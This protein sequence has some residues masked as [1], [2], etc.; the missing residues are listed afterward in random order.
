MGARIKKTLKVDVSEVVRKIKGKK[1]KNLYSGVVAD[2]EKIGTKKQIQKQIIEYEYDRNKSINFDFLNYINRIF[3]LGL[4]FIMP[5]YLSLLS[6]LI[7]A[8]FLEYKDKGLDI[9]KAFNYT[10]S[11]INSISKELFYIIFA[12]TFSVVIIKAIILLW[13][14]NRIISEKKAFLILKEIVNTLD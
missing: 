6:N 5:I 13:I 10:I 12:A 7:W 14:N 1:Y 4:I 9:S 11:Y 2:L 8:M 3:N